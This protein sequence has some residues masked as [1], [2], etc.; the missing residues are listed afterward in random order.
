MKAWETIN[1]Y[2]S[3][4]QE[5]ERGKVTLGRKKIGEGLWKIGPEIFL[6]QMLN[7]KYFSEFE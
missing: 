6:K 7:F 5:F 1:A 4:L 2:M 3:E